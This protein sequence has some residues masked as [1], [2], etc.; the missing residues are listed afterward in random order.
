[1]AD[2]FPMTPRGQRMLKEELERLKKVDRP[3][4]VRAI[5]EARAHGD[6]SENAEYHA[7]KERQSFIEGRIK[8]L[9]AKLALA[10]V[11][12]PARLSGSKV[13]FGATVTVQD[14]DNDEKQT[15]TIVGEDEADIKAGLLSISA[16][17]ARALIGRE[18][19]D[20]VRVRTPKGARELDIVEIRFV[21]V[22]AS[23]G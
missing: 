14:P 10:Q 11:I 21:A 4:N 8:D 19:G 13:V 6:L 9:D 17:V 2:Q 15:Y 20:T 16:P 12:D 3:E 23:V 1:M 5:E 18:V 22:S 7:A